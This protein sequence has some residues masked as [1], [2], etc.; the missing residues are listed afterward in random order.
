MHGPQRWWLLPALLL[1]LTACT[2]DHLEEGDGPDVALEIQDLTNEPVT[3][4]V[5]TGGGG[6]SLE[7]QDWTGNAANVPLSSLAGSDSVP[8]N[9]IVLNTVTI[10]YDWDL[11]GI[12]DP[13]I[14]PTRVVGLG[15]ITIAAG[16]TAPFSFSPISFQDVPSV[17]GQ[18][19]NLILDFAATTIE[20]EVLHVVARRQLFVEACAGP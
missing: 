12:P 9:D 3:A 1:A 6:C 13:A 15:A 17:T 18:T 8:F 10:S 14:T 20:G 11:D 16:G 5:D 2:N 19:G 4:N 7:V